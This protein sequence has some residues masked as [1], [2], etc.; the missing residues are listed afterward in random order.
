MQVFLAFKAKYLVSYPLTKKKLIL[1]IDKSES[2]LLWGFSFLFFFFFFFFFK[3]SRSQSAIQN[4]IWLLTGEWPCDLLL[5]THS[6]ISFYCYSIIW[7]KPEQLVTRNWFKANRY[8][9]KLH[10]CVIVTNQSTDYWWVDVP[11][12]VTI[13]LDKGGHPVNIFLIS[14]Q[15]HMLWVLIRSASARRF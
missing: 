13:G 3:H 1:L 12:L 6:P 15:K 7:Q 8:L 14:P 2:K 11:E 4:K 9:F 5:Y 10:K